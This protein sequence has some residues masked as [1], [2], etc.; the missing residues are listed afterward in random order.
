M[1]EVNVACNFCR[2]LSTS[3]KFIF[4]NIFHSYLF[5]FTYLY[6]IYTYY[7]FIVFTNQGRHKYYY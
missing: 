1:K 4:V 2:D 6:I 7:L 3:G 5:L